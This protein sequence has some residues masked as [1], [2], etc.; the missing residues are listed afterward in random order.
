[1]CDKHKALLEVKISMVL[2]EILFLPEIPGEGSQTSCWKSRRLSIVL[3]VSGKPMLGR[4]EMYL[5]ISKDPEVLPQHSQ[6]PCLG[7][8]HPYQDSP[9]SAFLKIKSH[10]KS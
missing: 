1:M 3:K 4:I 10:M 5:K 8:Y 2:E 6:L 9:N 7:Q